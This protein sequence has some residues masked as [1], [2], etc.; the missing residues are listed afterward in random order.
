MQIAVTGAT[1]FIG[2]Y[3]VRELLRHDH[4]LRCWRRAGSDLGGMEDVRDRVEWLEGEL[5]SDA[6][7]RDL[8]AG[9]DAVV[10]GALARAGAGFM[11]AEGEIL[12]FVETNVLGT[13]RLIEAARTAGVGR[14]VFISTCAVHDVILDDRPLDETHPL[15][16]K[17]HYG[18]HKGAIEKFVHSYGLGQGYPICAL[19]PTGV[20]GPDHP[21]HE[22]KWFGLVGPVAR[23]ETVTCERGG[24]EVHAADVA[25]AARLLLDAP[26]DQIAGQAFNCYDLY[27]SEWDVAHRAKELSGSGATIH[28]RQTSPKNQIETGKLRALGMTFGGRSQ[29]EQTIADLVAAAK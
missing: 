26:V 4:K 21:I 19:R 1:G 16:P 25:K 12:G 22:S 14:I 5:G 29:W 2:R 24:K 7:S 18:A 11:G 13:L 15:W 10:H 23:G 8:V 27:V 3:L 20:Y 28:G 9:C 17:S 6:A